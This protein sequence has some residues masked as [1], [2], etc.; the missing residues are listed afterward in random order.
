[1]S[2]WSGWGSTWGGTECGTNWP[3]AS[4]SRRGSGFSGNSRGSSETR[5]GRPCTPRRSLAGSGRRAPRS[6]TTTGRRGSASSTGHG[7]G[8][9]AT[10]KIG[11]KRVAALDESSPGMAARAIPVRDRIARGGHLTVG[12]RGGVR[13]LCPNKPRA[14]GG[15]ELS[16]VRKGPLLPLTRTARWPQPGYRAVCK[17]AGA[18]GIDLRHAHGPSGTLSASR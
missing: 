16:D 8:W 15:E 6:A 9:L 12:G 11:P 10:D 3:C 1:M 5:R 7:G 4:R 13:R 14:V 2:E 17:P 18:V